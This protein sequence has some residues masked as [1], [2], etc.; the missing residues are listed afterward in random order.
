MG[1]VTELR[2]C[3]PLVVA[4]KKCLVIIVVVLVYQRL[5]LHVHWNKFCC[6]VSVYEL[7]AR[8]FVFYVKNLHVIAIV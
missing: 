5:P 3:L 2:G 8:N 7:S 4:K 1:K 6:F